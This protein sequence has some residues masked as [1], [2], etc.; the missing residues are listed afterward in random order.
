[1][2]NN[3]NNIDKFFKDH[4]AGHESAPVPNAWEDMEAM[5]DADKSGL[6]I[7]N[8]NRYIL[9]S[10]AGAIVLAGAVVAYIS[11]YTT[12]TPIYADNNISEK[13]IITPA[14]AAQQKTENIVTVPENSTA[15]ASTNNTHKTLIEKNTTANTAI[16]NTVSSASPT[17]PVKTPHISEARN[18]IVLANDDTNEFEKAII[19]NTDSKETFEYAATELY[20]KK[21]FSNILLTSISPKFKIAYPNFIDLIESQKVFADSTQKAERKLDEI[22]RF[23]RTQFGIQAGTNFNK[24]LSNTSNSFQVGSGVMAGLFFSKNFNR[25][26]AINAEL[27][28][29]RSTGNNLM[30]TITQTEFFLEKT[31]TNFVLVTKTF[32]YIQLPISVSYSITQ[33]HKF[34]IGTAC[35]AIK[36]FYKRKD[37]IFEHIKLALWLKIFKS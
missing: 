1:M 11:G 6:L 31:T 4:L 34:S 24:V 33:K 36:R 19:E 8:I 29:L 27:N 7:K 22:Q 32:D 35:T 37:F 17:A 20:T 28:Y 15:V 5:L 30:R 10:I 14:P 18:P 9:T 3:I 13:Q 16:N 2:E 25:R 23:Y 26:W 12:N 21:D